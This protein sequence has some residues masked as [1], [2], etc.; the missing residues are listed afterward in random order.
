MFELNDMFV[1]YAWD[2][3]P[4]SA[5][6]D[7]KS[8]PNKVATSFFTYM[9]NHEGITMDSKS[10]VLKPFVIAT[11][12]KEDFEK[13]V[14]KLAAIF[15]DFAVRYQDLGEYALVI[16]SCSG[17]HPDFLKDRAKKSNAPKEAGDILR[18]GKGHITN[19]NTVLHLLG[20]GKR[21]Q[22]KD[23]RVSIL[24]ESE[25]LDLTP[26]KRTAFLGCMLVEANGYTSSVI[27]FKI[28]E[29]FISSSSYDI[30]FVTNNSMNTPRS[31]SVEED[32]LTREG[33]SNFI[34][35]LGT[36]SGNSP[37]GYAYSGGVH[38]QI[39]VGEIPTLAAMTPEEFKVEVRRRIMSIFESRRSRWDKGPIEIMDFDVLRG[40]QILQTLLPLSEWFSSS[41]KLLKGKEE[42]VQSYLESEAPLLSM[43]KNKVISSL[44]EKCLSSI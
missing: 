44:A 18:T 12:Y 41:G 36:I 5:G 8:L 23:R 32:L 9:T 30:P 11:S 43:S 42:A 10:V 3:N 26:Y 2:S 16:P 22:Y 4:V 17:F 14:E 19:A 27:E 37:R 6:L 38:L 24:E 29:F 25:E 33:F 15:Q 28:P 35:R 20:L 39:K 40:H 13:I 1:P 34:L 31:H 7:P 21:L